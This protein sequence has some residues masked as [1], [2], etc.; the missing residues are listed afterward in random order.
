MKSRETSS[1]KALA[2]LNNQI[3]VKTIE[4]KVFPG[5]KKNNFVEQDGMVKVY[6][7]APPVEG[8]AN[9]ALIDFLA[10]YYHVRK[11]QVK[12]IKGLK[13]RLK[14]VSINNL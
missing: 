5:S 4:L 14:T 12:I 11:S 9:K 3:T 7:T 10:D 6:L 13:S 2:V 8:K 1:P